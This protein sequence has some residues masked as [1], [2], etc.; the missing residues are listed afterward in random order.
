[1]LMIA[2]SLISASCGL[3]S[4]E[5]AILII[6]TF[7]VILLAKNVADLRGEVRALRRQ[8]SDH[9]AKK[10]EMAES[11]AAVRPEPVSVPPPLPPPDEIPADVYAA[12]IAAVHYAV[13]Q[14]Q[15]VVSVSPAESLLW[16]T[17]GRRNIFNSHKFR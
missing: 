10:V 8:Q 6:V 1:M 4:F 16:S 3:F 9:D 7:G 5:T 13:G 11:I 2:A 14:D 12:I 17:E 15:N